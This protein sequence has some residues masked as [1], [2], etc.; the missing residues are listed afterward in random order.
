[1]KYYYNNFKKISNVIHLESCEITKRTIYFFD[2]NCDL[3]EFLKLKAENDADFFK[4]V[5]TPELA[6]EL[7]L[8]VQNYETVLWLN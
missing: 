4:M 3:S 6:C 7:T 2:W 8:Q 5:Q 1:M